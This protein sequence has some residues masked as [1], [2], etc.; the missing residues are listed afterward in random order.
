MYLI[1][2]SKYPHLTL[3]S[4]LVLQIISAL[5]ISTFYDF[6]WTWC[7]SNEDV[8]RKMETKRTF[9]LKIRKFKFLE[10]IMRKMGVENLTL[11]SHI[12]D[13]SDRGGR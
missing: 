7:E 8:L 4:Q 5:L 6:L 1:E 2:L 3:V 12:E 10:Y 13:K 11:S 9:I